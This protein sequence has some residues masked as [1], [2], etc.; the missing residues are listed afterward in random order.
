MATLRLYR[1]RYRDRLTGR[2]ITARY[3]AEAI[4]I[5]MR[6]PEH[7]LLDV[8]VREAPDDVLAYFNPHRQP[9]EAC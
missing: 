4:V 7:E 9:G 5:R 1:F 2:R 3:R 8:E 6:H